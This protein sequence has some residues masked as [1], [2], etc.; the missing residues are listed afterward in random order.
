MSDQFEAYK[1]IFNSS[2]EG[3]MVV[4]HGKVVLANP[5]CEILFGYEKGELIGKSVDDFVPMGSR[6][7]HEKKRQSYAKKPSARQM[8]YGRDLTAVSKDGSNFPVEI[9]L[10]PATLN[11]EPSV[12]A[13]IIDIS[14]RKQVE[15]ELKK[16]E[17][18]LLQYAAELEKRVQD[19]TQE[20][21]DIVE[22][23]KSTNENLQSEV[24]YRIKAENEANIALAKEKEL[25]ELKTR[26]VSMASHEFR[27]PLSTILSSVSLIARYTTPETEEKKN[28]HITRIKNNVG[29]LTNILNDFLSLDKLDEGK[30]SVSVQTMDLCALIDE[31]ISELRTLTKKDQKIL[32]NI[33]FLN[34]EVQSD[35]QIIKQVLTNLMSN[36]IKY[37]DQ[38]SE[39]ELNASQNNEKITIEVKDQGIGIP[40]S[41]QKHL[42]GKFFRAHNSSHIQ[43][44]GLGLNI[45]QKYLELINGEITFESIE[46]KGSVFTI[47]LN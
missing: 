46:G 8:G 3:I 11:N 27:T 43:G 36:A 26:F 32:T 13:H 1:D 14:K 22:T 16:S 35:P 10:S 47:T 6:G 41:D 39:I 29:E 37:S 18:H 15:N 7:G 20:L 2:V 40:E 44:T 24:A 21:A 30:M 42:F 12:I 28:K 9:S 34:C 38:G 19:R 45:V 17:E 4:Q 31:T 5:Q 23:L 25:H 33:N